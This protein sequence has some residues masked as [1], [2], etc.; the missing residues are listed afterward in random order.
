VFIR[1]PRFRKLGPRVEVLA[2]FGDEPALVRE[3]H[4]LA[5]TFHPEIAGDARLHSLFLEN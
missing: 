3:D 4:L 2:R 5:A 1:A